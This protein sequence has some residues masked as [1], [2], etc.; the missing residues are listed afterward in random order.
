M[1]KTGKHITKEEKAIRISLAAKWLL[2]NPDARYTDFQEYFQ[3]KWDLSERMVAYYY[4]DGGKKANE[5]YD[6]QILLEK[7]RASISLMN[8]YR[9]LEA[10]ADK[11]IQEEKLLLEYRREVNKVLGLYQQN[12]DITTN[13]DNLE[14]FDISSIVG[15]SNNEDNDED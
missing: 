1:N 5:L 4:K 11:S 7:K 3:D 13:G 9:R 10:K 14:G 15:F 6:D 12:I 2:K 8:N